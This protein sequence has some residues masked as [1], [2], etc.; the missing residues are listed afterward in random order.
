MWSLSPQ[1][2]SANSKR[3][4]IRDGP[5]ENLWL[6]GGGG[7]NYKKYIYIRAR[8]N[9]MTKNSCT[10]INPKKY[11]CYGLKKIHTRNLITKINSC[12]SKIP[13]LPPITFQ[14]VR[15]LKHCIMRLSHLKAIDVWYNLTSQISDSLSQSTIRYAHSKSDSYEWQHLQ[16]RCLIESSLSRFLW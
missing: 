15:P 2:V 6:G 14:M 11:S 9:W 8:E 4:L 3:G 12:C 5:L 10:P 13:L 16:C 7:A 1:M